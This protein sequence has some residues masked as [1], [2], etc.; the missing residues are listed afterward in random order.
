[1]LTGGRARSY[2]RPARESRRRPTISNDD[3]A[4][5]FAA[6][7]GGEPKDQAPDDEGADEQGDE[8]AQFLAELFAPKQGDAAFIRSVQGGGTE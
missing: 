1:V 5:E 3:F 2:S 8:T 7:I 6:I 4:R